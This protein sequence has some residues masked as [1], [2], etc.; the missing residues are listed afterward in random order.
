[1]LM[2]FAAIVNSQKSR[3]SAR[4]AECQTKFSWRKPS[5]RNEVL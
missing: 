1:L 4:L 5:Y 3:V 2:G